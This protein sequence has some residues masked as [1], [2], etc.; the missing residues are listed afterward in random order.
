MKRALLI[1]MFGMLMARAEGAAAPCSSYYISEINIVSVADTDAG[2]VQTYVGFGQSS[3]DSEKNAM[4]ACSHLR[5]DLE[6]CLESDRRS[7]RN[8]HS[9]P[10]DNSLHLKYAKAVKRITGCE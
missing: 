9:D 3:E 7:G 6:T 1:L 10:A 8:A 4:G 5:F 2:N